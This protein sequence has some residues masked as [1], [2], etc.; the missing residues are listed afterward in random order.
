MH[1]IQS[2]NARKNHLEMF[3]ASSNGLDKKEP[4]FGHCLLSQLTALADKDSQD[5]NSEGLCQRVFLHRNRNEPVILI[6]AALGDSYSLLIAHSETCP[7]LLHPG[8]TDS[9]KKLRVATAVV[10]EREDAA[11]LLTKRTSSMK[12]FPNTWV[13]PGGHIEPWETWKEAVQR[14]VHE[15]VGL[16]DLY[17]LK[18]LGL[19]ES[20]YPPIWDQQ[21][22][23]RQHL[24]IYCSGKTTSHVMRPNEQEIDEYIWLSSIQVRSLLSQRGLSEQVEVTK[25]A[26]LTPHL[27]PL[28]QMVGN[29]RQRTG[30]TQG[31]R[32]ALNQHFRL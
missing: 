20:V 18:I 22:P 7:A 31:T 4:V 14:E 27:L 1:L 5:L 10:I 23:L 13:I 15:E 25:A 12:S 6:P 11:V 32:F 9:P 19:W 24:V 26:D 2:D 16:D 21:P 28:S 29:L 17:D 3:I 8:E 30:T